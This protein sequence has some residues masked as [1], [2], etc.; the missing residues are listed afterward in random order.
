MTQQKK[1]DVVGIG[2]AVVDVLIEADDA[3]LHKHDI[4]KGRMVLVEEDV[5]K[6]LY[7]SIT[8]Q[9]ELCG[10][11]VANSMVGLANL[12]SRC[13]FIGKVAEDELGKRFRDDMHSCQVAYGT[14]PLVGGV[15]TARCLVFV[16]PDSQRSMQTFLG[17]S[18]HMGMADLDEAMLGACSFVFLE[19]Y[20]WSAK[21]GPA[22][23]QQAA[24]HVHENGGR[25]AFS[26]S[27]AGLVR[28]NK[29]ELQAFVANHC[30]VVFANET[31]AVALIDESDTAPFEAEK[32]GKLLRE[33]VAFSVVTRS[34]KGSVVLAEDGSTHAIDA[35]VWKEVVDSTG[36]G[37]LYAAGFL[38]GLIQGKPLAMC[39][40][41]GAMCAAEVISHFGARPERSLAEIIA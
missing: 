24:T 22:M 26:L 39:G 9:R 36:A 4:P 33:L 38:H 37:D 30:D 28:A 29:A 1:W 10:G 21:E 19:G 31:E 18:I 3:F 12:G 17:A 41:Y 40:N 34:E 20:L 25:V 23:M 32:S 16:T 15:A 35:V 27:D 6:A 7:K 5:S 11:S 14:S 13:G 2:N 8:P